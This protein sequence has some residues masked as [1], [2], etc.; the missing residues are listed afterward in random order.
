MHEDVTAPDGSSVGLY[1]RLPPLGEP[2]VIHAAIPPSS[3]ILELGAGA[4]RI[5][6]ALVALGHRVVAVDNSPE[7]LEHVTGAEKV[8]AD[9]ETLRLGRR[10]PVVVLASN[11]A[12][13][14]RAEQRQ[15]VF[16]CCARHVTGTG[17]VLLQRIPPDWEPDS[18]W[19]QLGEIRARLRHFE[20]R[21]AVVDGEMEYLL[22][23]LRI[24][25]A[26]SSELLSDAEL[27][28]ELR[29]VGLSLRRVLD[30]PG[31]WIEAVPLDGPLESV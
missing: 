12:S 22:D 7:M 3:D 26:F 25:H 11:F 16:S 19:K 9:L 23:G 1:A 5:T 14:A 6:H 21:G 18:D 24:Q 17:Q 29:S 20:H 15:A 28:A 30:A 10:F 4:G 13:D 8:L 2:E 27:A 31:E